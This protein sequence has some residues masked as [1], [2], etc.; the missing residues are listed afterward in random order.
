MKRHFC[1]N[2]C[3]ILGVYNAI[4]TGVEVFIDVADVKDLTSYNLENGTLT[5]GAN[6]TLTNTMNLFNELS[7]QVQFSYLKKMAD[8]I[9]LIANVPVR[10]V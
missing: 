3:I 8:H 9:D 7:N 5:L 10:N 2:Q 1:L 4:A 6:M